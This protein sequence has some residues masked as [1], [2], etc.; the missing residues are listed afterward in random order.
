MMA[1]LILYSGHQESIIPNLNLVLSKFFS[2]G[3][4]S[5]SIMT[6]LFM[7]GFFLIFYQKLRIFP[8]LFWFC[9]YY[10]GLILSKTSIHG[11]YLI[12]PL[13]VYITIS[14]ISIIFLFNLFQKLLNKNKILIQTVIFIG[15]IFFSSLT[16][17]L[18]IIQID[19]EFDYEQSVRKKAGKFLNENTPVNST[20][21][22]EPIGV[23]GYFSD[24]Y[25]YDDA[26]LISPIFLE[27]NK[28]PYSAESVY[29]KIQFVKPDYIVLRDKYLDEFYSK[30]NLL[31]EYKSIKNF[32]YQAKEE[33]S[34][35]D[36]LTIFE[37]IN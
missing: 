25:I 36:D 12:P 34:G 11:W 28:L 26:A 4:Y 32:H 37:K 1:K 13:F 7:G 29:K 20:V 14:G 31:N 30:T 16:L 35:F 17:Y 21:F 27:F 23:I 24:R 22:L 6:A 10:L 9:I 15:V 18:K 8:M 5:S 3:F 2:S 19:E 33:S